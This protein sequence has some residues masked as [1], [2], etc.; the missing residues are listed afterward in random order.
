MMYV[1]HSEQD[2]AGLAT[3]DDSIEYNMLLNKWVFNHHYNIYNSIHKLRSDFC[4]IVVH[5]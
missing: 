4:I 3:D 5:S 2:Y 1:N